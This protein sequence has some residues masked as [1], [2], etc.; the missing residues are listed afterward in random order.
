M[1]SRICFGLILFLWATVCSCSSYRQGYQKGLTSS[2]E[3]YLQ[4]SLS[5]MRQGIK[6]YTND[7]GGPPQSLDEL[8]EE[9]Y[10]TH[11][12]RDMF[13]NEID[14]VI[15]RYDCSASPNCKPGIKDIHSASTMKSSKGNLYS[16]W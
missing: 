13:T 10:I 7:R 16:D 3:A 1:N 15:I 14:W 12:P 6:N 4:D 5:K 2:R 8:A 11:V 9:G